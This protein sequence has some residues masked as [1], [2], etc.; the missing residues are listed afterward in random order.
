MAKVSNVTNVPDKTPRNGD[1]FASGHKD[2]YLLVMIDSYYH[3]VGLNGGVWDSSKN[4]T[5]AVNGLTKLRKGDSL[6]L[7]QE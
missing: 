6:T 4:P 2:I 1:L 3:A 7:T 5:D